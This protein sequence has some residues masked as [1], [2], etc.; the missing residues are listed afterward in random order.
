M[1]FMDYNLKAE[2]MFQD[3]ERV[4]VIDA[5]KFPFVPTIEDS[6]IIMSLV[7]KKL[8]EEPLINRISIRQLE[9]YDYYEDSVQILKE[10]AL[11][12]KSIFDDFPVLQ[13]L[14]RSSHPFYNEVR[15]LLSTLQKDYLY[16]PISAYLRAKRIYRKIV[17]VS[18]K[19]KVL[20]EQAKPIIAF[21]TKF[22]A[23][24]E[25]ARFYS[26]IKEF[27]YGLKPGDRKIYNRLFIADVKPTFISVEYKSRI[28]KDANIIDTYRIDDDTDVIIFRMPGVINA[29]YY[30]FPPEYSIFEKEYEILIRARDLLLKYQPRKEDY[31]DL[32]RLREIYE[33]II[34][35]IIDNASKSVG[36]IL[37]KRRHNILR[38][39]LMRYTIGFGI[40]EKIAKD[41]RLSDIFINPPPGEVPVSVNHIDY[42]ICFTNV[43]LTPKEVE[44][45]ATKFRLISGRPL[46]EANP[47]LDTEISFGDTRLR[48]AIVMNPLSPY[49]LSFVFRRHRSKPWTLPLFIDNRTLDPIAAGLLSFLVDNGRSILIAGTR[50]S[51][52]TSLL[53]ALLL[54]I[55]RK[56]RIITIEDT[57]EIPTEYMR[58]LGYN[59]LPLKV[60]SPFALQSAEL[61]AEDGVRVSLRLGDSAIVLGEVRSS[62]AKTLYEAMRVG[63]LAN[64][65]LGTIHAESPYGVY[66]RVVNDLGVP[67]TSFKATDIVVIVNPIRSPDGLKK[68]R[69]VLRITEVRKHWEIDPLKERGFV[70]L[71]VYNPEKDQLEMTSDLINGDSDI[72][73]SVASRIKLLAGSWEKLWDS[74]MVRADSKKML[75]DY[76][77]KY[78]RKDILEADFV[79][80]ANDKLHELIGDVVEEI[81][82]VDRKEI[83]RRFEKWLK[84]RL[85]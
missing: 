31:Y 65:V 84:E 39:I 75:V 4:L 49:G 74:V 13:S 11:I 58:K 68:Y 20:Q 44:S 41:E 42:D 64:A 35:Q 61:S 50:G 2:V 26:L 71:M 6:P 66:D 21:L 78:N 51:G 23:Q 83:L 73:K 56:T 27:V 60:R 85:S 48:A 69:R 24:F 29:F 40:L 52:K 14:L 45:W 47:V 3:N 25:G 38:E 16:D 70:D 22:F 81:G 10:M 8:I 32:T 30:I 15:A 63:A 18:Q 53:G 43:T 55:P 37:T 19:N 72:L 28:P 7:L 62:E 80:V 33:N 59:I 77:R 5:S 57:L 1:Y 54:E 34:D 82:T 12:Y 67:K 17:V 36:H 76:A 46:D 79:V 9:E